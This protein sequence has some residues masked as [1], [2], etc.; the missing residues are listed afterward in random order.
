[1]FYHSSAGFS[2]DRERGGGAGTGFR[3]ISHI[4]VGSTG[5]VAGHGSEYMCSEEL[6]LQLQ[7]GMSMRNNYSILHGLHP[8]IITRIQKS[9][10]IHMYTIFLCKTA[11]CTSRRMSG[12][13][14]SAS[15]HNPSLQTQFKSSPLSLLVG[16]NVTE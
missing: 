12:I 16:T 3:G 2:W 6:N 15:L 13:T 1:M 10:C 14:H 8:H 9:I 4:A 5:D 7:C 11:W